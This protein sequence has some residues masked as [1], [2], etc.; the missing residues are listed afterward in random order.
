[1]LILCHLRNLAL[2]SKIFLKKTSLKEKI[3]I[4]RRLPPSRWSQT[5]DSL[6]FHMKVERISHIGTSLLASWNARE[7]FSNWPITLQC[8]ATTLNCV[9]L[10]HSGDRLLPPP[11]F[12]T[13]SLEWQVW[14]H[15]ASQS[16]SLI[17][18]IVNWWDKEPKQPWTEEL[19]VNDRDEPRQLAP[20]LIP[21][22][23]PKLTPELVSPED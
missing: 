14:S 4:A 23:I 21:K 7:P 10:H 20:E 1:M 11:K 16:I 3:E 19:K 2:C 6:L 8:K 5:A 22:L 18:I 15:R 13:K 9:L 17:T 12:G